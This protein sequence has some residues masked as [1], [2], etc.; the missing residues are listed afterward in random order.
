MKIALG[1]SR[2][3]GVATFSGGACIRER[4][5]VPTCRDA[6]PAVLHIDSAWSI[7]RRGDLNP[8]HVFATD[9]TESS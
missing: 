2:A 6:L 4:R 8:Q 3:A 7:G 5:P 1:S 9:R